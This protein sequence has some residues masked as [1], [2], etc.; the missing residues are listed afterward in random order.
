[1]SDRKAAVTPKL[2]E[3]R[4]KRDAPGALTSLRVATTLQ[5]A[6]SAGLLSG[7]K[8]KRISG[9]AHQQ[10]FETA[11]RRSGLD[12]SEL[13]EYALAKVALEDDFAEKLLGQMGA[14]SRDIDLE[15]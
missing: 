3:P 5:T 8:A 13:I 14:V 1:M 6:Q 4:P 12:G 10:L 7:R 11:A 15:F 2:K 9:R